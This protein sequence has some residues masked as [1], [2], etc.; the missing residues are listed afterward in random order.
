MLNKTLVFAL[1][2]TVATGTALAQPVSVTL[3]TYNV[4]GLPWPVASDRTAALGAIASQLTALRAHGQQPN[5]VALQEAFIPEAKA[6]GKAAG[7]RYMALGPGRYRA[8]ATG[9]AQDLAFAADGS[10]LLGEGIGK[11]VDS[12]LVIF[13]DYPIVAVRRM[14]YGVC[15]GY[16]CLANK[17]A[18][19]AQIKI[20]GSA[21]PLTVIDSHLNS[22]LAS[23]ATRARST[24]AYQRQLDALR[25]FI[26]SVAATGSPVLI[27]ADLN[28][29]HRRE[30]LEYFD[31][32]LLDGPTG[33]VAAKS[34][35]GN[36]S[37][38][39]S[40]GGVAESIRHGHDW[41]LYRSSSAMTVRPTNLIA[42]FG[43]SADG[44]MLSDHIGLT[45][46]YV[47]DARSPADPRRLQFASR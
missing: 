19:A 26:G 46:T 16:D 36:G 2:A 35:C 23:G 40:A 12:G 18:L 10:V 42:S 39:G 32:R 33:F 43:R 28:V 44:S 1:L 8:A 13:S 41:L 11:R 45:A 21:L 9:T 37:T 7:Y 14:S 6:I 25:A 31:A 27:A 30:R 3:M 20:P 15:A 47:L 38:C 17:G 29:G 34:S 22:G 4:K 5:V 24:Y